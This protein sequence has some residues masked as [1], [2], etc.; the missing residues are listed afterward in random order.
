MNFHRMTN[1]Q[2]LDFELVET[3]ESQ[4][5]SVAYNSCV[6]RNTQYSIMQVKRDMSLGAH[7]ILA[8]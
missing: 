4:H 7:M 2:W 1:F 5:Y 3:I 8:G 6:S